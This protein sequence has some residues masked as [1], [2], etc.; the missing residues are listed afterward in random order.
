LLPLLTTFACQRLY[1]HII[2]VRHIYPG[3]HLVHH[4]FVGVL[5]VI[6]TAFCLAF[7]PRL[8]AVAMLVR[9]A[10]GVGSAMVL[11]EIAYLVL[12]Q[13][14][15]R[16]Y[17]SDTSLYGAIGFISLAAVLLWLLSRARGSR[18]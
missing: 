16:D 12:R 4:L 13:A 15:D 3:G 8:R 6:P 10:L 14:S 18:G 2:G 1:L 11:D 7:G 17:V 9:V 5:I